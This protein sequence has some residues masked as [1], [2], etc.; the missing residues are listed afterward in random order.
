[1][2]HYV[3]CPVSGEVILFWDDLEHT[4]LLKEISAESGLT[5]KEVIK[6]ALKVVSDLLD[7][8]PAQDRVGTYEFD[9]VRLGPPGPEADCDLTQAWSYG[10]EA[11]KDNEQALQD[12]DKLT[13]REALDIFRETV[14]WLRFW[15]TRHPHAEWR[16]KFA[17]E[18]KAAE[19]DGQEII[20]K[21]KAKGIT[22]GAISDG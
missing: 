6:V 22:I 18:L 2:E 7:P 8:L 14:A 9:H 3:V 15:A 19:A 16:Q 11:A 10:I 4:E 20:E 12:G 17:E 13:L 1:M 21:A 5:I